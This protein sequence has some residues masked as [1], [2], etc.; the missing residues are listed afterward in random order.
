MI[1]V[2]VVVTVLLCVAFF[3]HG[4]PWLSRALVVVVPTPIAQHVGE[5]VLDTLDTHFLSPSTLSAEEQQAVSAQFDALQAALGPFPMPPRL[6]FRSWDQGPN[7]MALSDGTVIVLDSLV[8]MAETPEQLAGILL[9]ELGHVQHEHVM[10][11]LVRSALLSVTM[12]AITGESGGVIDTL[13]G[14]GVFVISQG[15]SRSAEEEADAYAAEHMQQL[16]GSVAPMQA[17]FQALLDSAEGEGGD[18]ETIPQWLSTHPGLAERIEALS[19][20]VVSGE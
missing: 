20:H 13:S 11:A 19:G 4:I 15:F 7:A 10:V 8:T 12:M 3:T 17:M 1:G 9:H 6:L 18:E 14:A 5:Q 2:S 16:Y